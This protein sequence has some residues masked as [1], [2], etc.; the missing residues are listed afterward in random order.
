VRSLSR[1]WGDRFGRRQPFLAAYLVLVLAGAATAGVG[2][3]WEFTAAQATVRLATAAVTSLGI[4]LVAE[5]MSQ[6]VRAYGISI[7]GAAGS[8]GAGMALATLP[9]ADRGPDGWR[10]P[11][12]L[13]L[14]GL[15]ALPFLRRLGEGV[16]FTAEDEQPRAPV[17]HLL[18]G[19]WAARFWT[20]AAIGFLAAAFTSVGLA[21]ATERLVDDL[22]LA[23]G[24]A[25]AISL[26]GGVIGV[27]GF[28]AGGRMADKWGRR[29]TT[30][31]ALVA[32]VAGGSACSG[33]PNRGNWWCRWWCHAR[34]LTAPSYSPP[35]TGH[36]ASTNLAML[37][38][39]TG[40]LVGTLTIDTIGL[41]ETITGLG[42]GAL[43]S[44]AHALGQDRSRP[45]P[46]GPAR[47]PEV[48]Y[49]VLELNH[50]LSVDQG[51]WRLADDRRLDLPHGFWDYQP[52]P[53]ACLPPS[54]RSHAVS[55]LPLSTDRAVPRDPQHRDYDAT[56]AGFDWDEAEQ[57]LDRI[58]GG[59]NIAHEA[60]DRNLATDPA[61]T[62]IRWRSLGRDQLPQLAGCQD[63]N[64]DDPQVSS[65]NT[66]KR[67]C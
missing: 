43:G 61:E 20:V 50:G 37:G 54:S 14:A 2:S 59:W 30:V 33:F 7:Y 64:P 38:S 11:F 52:W 39:T 63:T 45:R 24:T 15:V 56:R 8:L 34:G 29:P 13:G 51:G 49:P 46:I 17:R 60:V 35:S 53:P 57:S 28:F 9:L 19:P 1:S 42:L 32:A 62:V 18:T 65:M 5:Q 41:S 40:L 36:R 4:V 47:A 55:S 23:T 22:G 25:V 58:G 44:G 48:R 6:P 66:R 16:V 31:I 3:A 12:A 26:A 67:M 10:L 27:V 21:F